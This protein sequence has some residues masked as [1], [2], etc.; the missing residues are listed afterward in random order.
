M[1]L[2][3]HSTTHPHIDGMDLDDWEDEV[4]RCKALVEEVSG[5]PAPWFRYPFLQRGRTPETR[6]GGR[7][8]LE[9]LGHEVA[10]VS[11]D[12]GEW[13][14]NRPYVN[15]LK[16]GERERAAMIRQTF[17]DHVVASYLHYRAVSHERLGRD[18]S[19]VLLLHAHALAADSLDDLLGALEREGARFVSLER[20]LEDPVYRR[21]DAYA[22]PIGLS[23]LYRI[24]PDAGETWAWDAGQLEALRLRVG[25]S[26]DAADDPV[27]IDRDLT[28]RRLSAGAWVVVHESPWPANSLVAE[29]A[30]GSLLLV[31]TPY[32]PRATQVLLDWLRIRFGRRPVR[33]V[34]THFHWDALGGNEAL[35]VAEIDVHG[36]DLT[37][38]LLAE[39][40]EAMREALLRWLSS[41]PDEAEPFRTL[42]ARPP[43]RTFSI[44]EGLQLQFGEDRVEVLFPGPGHSPD[45]VVVHLPRHRILFGGCLVAAGERIGNTDDADLE[46]WPESIEALRRF[47]VDHVVP[48]HGDRTDP[49]LLEHTLELLNEGE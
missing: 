48:G 3:N 34:N 49:G 24:D 36:S 41:R 9:K 22:G 44:G 46:R 42:S 28:I 26:D 17:V 35:L 2:G 21:H 19:H 33:A 45:G 20:A 4:G 29:M 5:R 23:W 43:N 40:E 6:D 7:A 37:A 10:T 30:D 12:T 8:R 11:V 47:D 27:R 15:A 39:R 31:D 14:L 18:P 32:T 38:E 16:A 25:L 1:E 13:V